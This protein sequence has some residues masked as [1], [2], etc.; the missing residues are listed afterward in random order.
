MDL[1]QNNLDAQISLMNDIL[2]NYTS[3][4]YHINQKGKELLTTLRERVY[5]QDEKSVSFTKEQFEKMFDIA[6][7]L[8]NERKFE[9]LGVLAATAAPDNEIK[10]GIL[11]ILQKS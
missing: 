6:S 1:K 10:K 8:E 7:I 2:S 4:I 3:I 9:Q 11:K 5:S